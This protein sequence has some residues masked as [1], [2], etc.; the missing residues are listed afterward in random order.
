MAYNTD[1]LV[2]VTDFHLRVKLLC[3]LLREGV[4][5]LV[6]HWSESRAFVES[7]VMAYDM[8]GSM[9]VTDFH[10]C[11]NLVRVFTLEICPTSTKSNG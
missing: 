9:W 5:S 7:R 10:L 4:V 8:D 2:W 3:A 6:S 11:V 1:G